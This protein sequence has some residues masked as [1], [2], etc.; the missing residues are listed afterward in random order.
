MNISVIAIGKIKEKYLNNAVAH[1]LKDLSRFCDLS[2]IELKDEKTPDKASEKEETSI[3]KI[4]GNRILGRIRDD[5]FLI[6]L[7]I[8][9]KMLTSK[10]FAK[11]VNK[12]RLSKDIVFV[13]GGSLG[14]STEVLERSNYAISFSK[15]TYPHQL[16]RVI[17]LEQLGRCL[18]IVR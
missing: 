6:T 17:L 1:Y 2:I 13:I 12:H 3:K 7:E 10:G 8:Q 18:T 15:M 16:M 11:L 9:G 14:L 4:E 5:Q